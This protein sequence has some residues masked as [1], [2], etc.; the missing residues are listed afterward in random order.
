M[1]EQFTALRFIQQSPFHH[2]G[3]IAV[4]HDALA[5]DA[6]P[7]LEQLGRVLHLPA[8]IVFLVDHHAQFIEE[9]KLPGATAAEE[10]P[11]EIETQGLHVHHVPA[12]HVLLRRHGVADRKVRRDGTAF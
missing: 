6:V 5:Q 7:A 2:A 3:V 8:S 9:I 4:T 10:Y 11:A 12:E 1:P